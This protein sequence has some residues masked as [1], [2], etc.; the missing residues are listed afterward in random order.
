MVFAGRLGVD[1]SIDGEPMR[2]L[3]AE[4]PG[5]V[6]ELQLRRRLV[7]LGFERLDQPGEL[8]LR[9]RLEVALHLVAFTLPTLAFMLRVWRQLRQWRVPVKWG[10]RWS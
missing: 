8:L 1:V 3:F 7:H 5:G 4:E 2:A 6:L 9:E 10:P